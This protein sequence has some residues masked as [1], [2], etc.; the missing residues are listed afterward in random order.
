MIYFFK[1]TTIEK[2]YM[3]RMKKILFSKIILFAICSRG[4][5]I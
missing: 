3:I 2:K 4:L 1:Q 5:K